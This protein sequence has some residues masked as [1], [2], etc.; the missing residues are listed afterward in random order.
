MYEKVLIIANGDISNFKYIG[1]FIAGL[2]EKLYIICCDGGVRHAFNLGVVPNVIIGDMDSAKDYIVNHFKG[3]EVPFVKYPREK[4]YTDLE[5]SIDHAM[6]LEF[7]I[8]EIKIIGATG[9]RLDHALANIHSIIRPVAAGIDTFIEDEIGAVT[10]INSENK[11]KFPSESVVSLIPL[12]TKVTG[13]TTFD[14][15]YPLKGETLEVG[16]SRGVSNY[17]LG[18]NAR[19]ELESGLLAVFINKTKR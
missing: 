12:T 15:K 13:V 1:K 14:F 8:S 7:P 11:L 2:G 5:L 19:V 6:S 16:S 9:G 10:V 3:H 4:D 17:S 18:N